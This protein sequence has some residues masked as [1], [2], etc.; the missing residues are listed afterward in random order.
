MQSTYLYNYLLLS[1]NSSDAQFSQ[2]IPLRVKGE[3]MAE[4][5]SFP[6]S[7]TLLF[8]LTTIPSLSTSFFHVFFNLIGQSYQQTL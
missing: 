3:N 8:F 7:Y 5:S 4:V 6:C 1:T 2:G